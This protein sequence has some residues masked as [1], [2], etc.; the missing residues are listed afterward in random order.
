MLKPD[1]R[2]FDRQILS[3]QRENVELKLKHGIALARIKPL[4]Q[5]LRGLVTAPV[6]RDRIQ[7]L[8]DDA[9]RA[10]KADPYTTALKVLG[11]SPEGTH[12]CHKAR[13]N[14]KFCQECGKRI[15]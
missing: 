15:E 7:Q 9:Y 1:R 11:Y 10:K 3:L 6:V 4:E 5:A 14:P 12:V 2:D 8:S 13:W